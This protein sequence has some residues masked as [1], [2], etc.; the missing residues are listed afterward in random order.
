[1]EN[2]DP[3][4]IKMHASA[5]KGWRDWYQEQCD[6]VREGIAEF[7]ERQRATAERVEMLQRL[8][9]TVVLR[10]HTMRAGVPVCLLT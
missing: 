6:M 9:P 7:F 10:G 3:R 5:M 8:E 2:D 1:M 4:A